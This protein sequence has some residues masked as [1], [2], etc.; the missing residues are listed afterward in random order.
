MEES[1]KKFNILGEL[2]EITLH[3]VEEKTADKYLGEIHKEAM[4]L[5]RIF[6]PD[7][8]GSELSV[9]N[10]RRQMEVSNELLFAIRKGIEFSIITSGSYDLSLGKKAIARKQGKAIPKTGCSYKDIGIRQNIITQRHTITLKHE[11]ILLDLGIIAKGYITEKLA[12]FIKSR[13]IKNAFIDARKTDAHCEDA[14]HENPDSRKVIRAKEPT[15]SL[16]PL[17]MKNR[18]VATIKDYERY[19]QNHDRCDVSGKN[20]F[21]SV[22]VIAKTLM[23]ADAIATAIFKMG[24]KNARKFLSKYTQFQVLA[25]DR[26]LNSHLFNGFGDNSINKDGG[27]PIGA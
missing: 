24:L 8:P 2:V 26:G 9:L 15:R 17:Y 23:D 14:R 13:G 22:N 12:N 11:D 18:A 6:D 21:I 19:Y 4:R 7:N 10:R 25:I 5:Q 1:K 27:V 3:S 16:Y 20:E